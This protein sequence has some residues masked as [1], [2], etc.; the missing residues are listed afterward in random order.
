MKGFQKL[1]TKQEKLIAC[2]IVEPTIEKACLKA[3]VTTVTYWR[4][5]RLEEFKHEYRAAR[6]TI[7]ENTISRLQVLT[8]K[9]VDCLERNLSCEAPG[10]EIRAAQIV[11]ELSMKG[12]EI[13]DIENRIEWLENVVESGKNTNV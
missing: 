5:N 13:L 12:L 8:N 10:S 1:S 11:L 3:G 6:R 7:L 2:L 9:A 4:W